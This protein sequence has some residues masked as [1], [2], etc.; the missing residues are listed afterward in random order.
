MAAK[1]HTLHCHLIMADIL[2]GMDILQTC[3]LPFITSLFMGYDIRI[4]EYPVATI[5]SEIGFIVKAHSSQQP[6]KPLT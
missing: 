5:S 1:F 4:H 3:N 2:L 6:D